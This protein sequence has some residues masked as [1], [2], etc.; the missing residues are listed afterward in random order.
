MLFL[1]DSIYLIYFWLILA[2]VFL[3]IEMILSGLFCFIAFSCGCCMAAILAFFG[4]SFI[5]Q[6][7]VG[8]CFTIVSFFILKH[9]FAAKISGVT[10]DTNVDA[11]I[12]KK[13]MVV[14]TIES[15][16]FGYVKVR[17]ERWMAECADNVILQK[18]T[19]VLVVNVKGNRLV[20][21]SKS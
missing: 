12:G 1:F 21:K 5:S 18:G 9:F 2:I 13:C 17:G 10:T 15:N 3:F 8:F 7:I 6:C 20:V 19:E 4:L 11:L 16:A 14:K